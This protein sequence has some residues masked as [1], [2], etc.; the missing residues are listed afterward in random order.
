MLLLS[1]S[2]DQIGHDEGGDHREEGLPDPPED[3][4]QTYVQKVIASKM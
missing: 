4:G 1:L 2:E 3:V